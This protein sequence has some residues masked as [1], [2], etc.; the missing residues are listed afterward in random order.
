MNLTNQNLENDLKIG[1]IGTGKMGL[2]MAMNLLNAGFA[3]TAYDTDRS[4][5]LNSGFQVASSLR[6]LSE[7]ASIL[8][9]MIPDDEALREVVL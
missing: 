9:S 1:W 7:T 5:L 6:E 3:V 2:P 8:I 4:R